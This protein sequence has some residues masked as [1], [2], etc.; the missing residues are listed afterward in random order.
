MSQLICITGMDGT[1]KSTLLKNLSS[2]Y[3]SSYVANIWDI[4]EGGVQTVPFKS[5]KDIDAYLCE[6]SPDSRLLFLT[7]AL[8]FSLDRALSSKKEI[9]FLNSY[10]YKYFATELALG[11]GMELA[12]TLLNSF[13]EPDQTFYLEL[14]PEVVVSRKTV[15]SRYECGLSKTP[16]NLSFMEF[17]KLA[18]A[19][20]KNFDSTDFITLDAALSEDIIAQEVKKRLLYP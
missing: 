11:A 8:R 9:V 13:P 15:F 18:L 12:E 19:Q 17:Q 5:K 2:V 20:W 7:H 10:Y 16:G 3:P 14:S 4:M 1:G 6:L